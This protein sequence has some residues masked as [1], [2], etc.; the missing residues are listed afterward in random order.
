MNQPT[1]Y[2]E[3]EQILAETLPGY[4]SR[5]QQTALAE[6]VERIITTESEEDEAPALGIAQAGT[7]T[8]KS[9]GGLIPAIVSRKRVV[10]ATATKA[11]QAQLVAKDVPFLQEKLGVPFTWA[12]LKGRSN[13]LCEAKLN[14]PDIDID[15]ALLE[16]LRA[17]MDLEG[18][19]GDFDKITSIEGRDQAK[20]SMSSKECP[21]KSECPF[22]DVCFAEGAKAEARAA[23]LVV[24]NTAMLAT[25]AKLREVTFGKAEMLGS[26][27]VLIV[28]EA[29]RLEEV[30]T[31]QFTERLTQAG[32][33]KS[34]TEA[35][36]FCMRNGTDVDEALT[37]SFASNLDKV[38]SSII[39]RK[40]PLRLSRGALLQSIGESVDTLCDSTRA[41]LKVVSSV[42]PNGKGQQSR[43]SNIQA[44]LSNLIT[45]YTSLV[46]ADD[47]E[48]V[49]WVEMEQQARGPVKAVKI[50]P[51]SV[52]R[53]L[54]D[55]IWS[56]GPAVAMSATITQGES[57]EFAKRTLGMQDADTID[58]G[59]PFDFD[60]QAML[61]VPS[62]SVPTPKERD[63]WLSWSQNAMIDMVRASGGGA[64]L[65]FTSR[66]AMQD[67]YRVLAPI[68]IEEDGLNCFVQDGSMSTKLLAE[69]FKD[70]TDSVL[71]GLKSFFEGVDV[72]GDSCRLVIIDKL[73]FPV[74]TDPIF[75]A[76][77]DLLDR[78]G[79]S[80][81]RDLSVPL[82]TLTLV[83]AFGRLIRTKSDRG[84]VAIL[85]SRL[86]STA[87]G[88]QIV[89][90][91]PDCPATTDRKDVWRFFQDKE[92]A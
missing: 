32:A 68:F 36:N 69:A 33:Q 76:R 37:A 3:A 73:P 51:V 11:L 62:R 41:I 28:D 71:F 43:K 92:A 65:L 59:T 49:R 89:N 38:W 70:D 4:E 6:F 86:S 22:G 5:P 14:S 45:N 25:D 19:D 29:H 84:V 63:S 47:D 67:A 60:N 18:F 77:G 16:A 56:V 23:D 7:G 9:F 88:R 30:F 57:F 87:W 64:M 52:A 42:Q 12:L 27:D 78:Q 79:K 46:T 66:S 58:V 34:L 54:Q 53:I 26:W 31:S 72:Q 90:S 15:P 48:Y 74:P 55:H 17:E 50:A 13:Y 82:M 85:D 44:Q 75:S 81:F 35:E 80:S 24:T 20:L 61:Y 91:L 40:D 2:A 8:G 83:Q 10:I 21:G 39:S 1:T